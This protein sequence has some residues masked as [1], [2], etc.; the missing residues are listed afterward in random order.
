EVY[1]NK[2]YDLPPHF[3]FP[4]NLR[5]LV[6]TLKKLGPDSAQYHTVNS[7]AK[8]QDWKFEEAIEEAARAI[9]VNPKFLRAHGLYA[10]HVLYGRGDTDTALREYRIAEQLDPADV[11]IQ[12]VLGDVYYAQ[13]DYTNAIEQYNKAMRLEPRIDQHYA[14][15]RAYEAAHSYD[16]AMDEHETNAVLNF[17]NLWSPEA[18][19]DWWKQMHEAV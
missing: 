14:L 5:E 16:Q 1:W 8:F 6:L 2:G 7:W 10:S 17:A 12:I 15:A 13:H 9:K 11:I 4:E 18:S 19:R 3:N